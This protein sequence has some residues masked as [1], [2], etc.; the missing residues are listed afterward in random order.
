MNKK[1]ESKPKIELSDQAK[2]LKV[3]IYEHFKGKKYRVLG[4]SLHSE[5]LEELVIY[6]A[7]YGDNLIWARPIE[8]F[9]DNKNLNDR[10]E[11]PR[12]KYIK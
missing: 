7:L 11:V 6:Q 9:L 10:Q 4:V 1:P 8:M 2:S 5:R 3:G 12:F